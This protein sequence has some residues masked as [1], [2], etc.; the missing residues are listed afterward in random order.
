M[1]SFKGHL[2]QDV[3]EFFCQLLSKLNN[4]KPDP[5]PN[6]SEEILNCVVNRMFTG[7]WQSEVTCIGCGNSNQNKEQFN[8]LPLEFPNKYHKIQTASKS[9]SLDHLLQFYTQSERLGRVYNC[10]N[11]TATVN[12][13]ARRTSVRTEAAKRIT[14]LESPKCL[15]VHLKRAKYSQQVGQEKITCH[16]DFPQSLN[17]GPYMTHADKENNPEYL[18]RA[19]VVHHG[20]HF[21]SGHYTTFCWIDNN[22]KKSSHSGWVEYNDSEVHPANIKDVL[23]SQAY[24]LLYVD[25]DLAN[26]I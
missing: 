6:C 22:N 25:R 11:C 12:G 19:V 13:R 18:L 5:D 17:L 1:P 8:T 23:S 10:V 15:F 2:Q 24:M 4:E 26:E 9:I 16:V 14:V 7:A 21:A 3:Q 20:K